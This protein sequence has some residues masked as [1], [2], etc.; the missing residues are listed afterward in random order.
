MEPPDSNEGPSSYMRAPSLKLNFPGNPAG[1][2]TEREPLSVIMDIFGS[3]SNV[4]NYTSELNLADCSPDPVAFGGFAEVY[5]ATLRNGTQVAVKCVK[6][7]VSSDY[8]AVKYTARELDAWSNLRHTNILELLGMA[9]FKGRL[10]L[11]S[12]WMDQGNVVEFINRNDGLVN[13]FDMSAQVIGAVAFLHRQSVVHGDLKAANV[14]ISE[15]GTPKLADFGLTITHEGKFQFSTTNPGGGTMRWM[16]PELFNEH[17]KRSSQTDVYALGMTLL[18][19][20]TGREP[21]H[22][23]LGHHIPVL[24]TQERRIPERPSYLSMRSEKH[25]IFWS[26][27]TKCWIYEANKRVKASE[28]EVLVKSTS[29]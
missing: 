17:G 26:V 6:S 15:D 10:A 21:F 1:S 8:T 19:I 9:L 29:V 14:L 22:D 16:A 28:L 5:T 20:F 7:S 24:V 18:E 3:F 11:V 2:S 23:S 4:K 12:N 25:D 13:R 27:L